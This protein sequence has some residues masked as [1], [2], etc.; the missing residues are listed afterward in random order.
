MDLTLDVDDQDR[1]IYLCIMDTKSLSTIV[2][3]RIEPKHFASDVRQK[4]F[5]TATDFFKDYGKAPGV[6]IVSEI[7]SK[8]R[9][10]KI[11]EEDKEAY[12]EYLMKVV[13][14]PEFSSERIMDRLGY[15]TKTRIVSTVTNSL[16]RIQD[17]FD[18]EP[19]K[20]LELM[21]EA[22]FEADISTGQRVIESIQQ[23]PPQNVQRVDFLTK[24]NIDP[25]DKMLGGGFKPTN[26]AIIQAY[27]GM[28]KSWCINHLAKMAVR[29]GNSPLVIPTEMAN[30]TA[31][32]R[33]RMSFTGFTEKEVFEK[34]G[35]VKRQ[36][37]LSM[38]KGADIFLI[39]EEEKSMH[40]DEL[41]AIVEDAETKTG[42]EIK[43]ILIDSPD[44]LLPPT[45]KRYESDISSNTAIHTY[46][47][48]YAKNENKCVIGTAQVQRKGE[49]KF[50]LGPNNVGDNINKFRKATVGISINGIPEEKSKWM[51]RLWLFKNTD[52]SEGARVW[53]KR[54]FSRGQ[55]ITR[56]SNFIR[57]DKYMDMLSK[58][59]ILDKDNENG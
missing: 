37:R 40:V 53:I 49:D 45:G 57:E 6:D 19:D 2:R 39:S 5:K 59:P 10:K 23:D 8:I 32:L 42:R 24:F 33:F 30:R 58:L 31:R 47:K 48:N 18:I 46:L 36:V 28:G 14:I 9:H 3:Q 7:D 27:L 12:E 25:I 22:I 51:Y 35:D 38:N 41:P 29:F 55:F 11:K 4:V 17:R 20:A 13:S 54:D 16:L 1:I 43:L 21:R 34:I 15:F 56:Y 26:Y 44:D 52:G 50:W